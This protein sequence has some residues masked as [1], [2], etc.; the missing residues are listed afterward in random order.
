MPI[1]KIEKTPAPSSFDKKFKVKMDNPKIM[2]IIPYQLAKELGWPDKTVI[3]K[4]P[5]KDKRPEQ[6]PSNVRPR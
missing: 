2:D 1:T 5:R 6:K 4:M 3:G